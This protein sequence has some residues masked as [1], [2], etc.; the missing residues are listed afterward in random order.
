M[1][2]NILTLNNILDLEQ[3]EEIQEMLADV[4]GMAL[5]TVDYKGVPKTS[6]S[7]CNSFCRI[8]RSN[9]E[10]FKI[11]QRCDSRAGFEAV[12][13]NGPFIYL[14]HC[15][16]V[17]VAIPIIAYEKY[18]GA[19]MAGQVLLVDNDHPLE[20][21]INDSKN[22]AFSLGEQ[23]YQEYAKLPQFTYEKIEKIANMIWKIS[24]YIIKD[25]L[26]K[27][28]LYNLYYKSLNNK[29]LDES[30]DPEGFSITNI[31]EDVINEITRSTADTE[32]NKLTAK[33]SA[34]ISPT[35]RPAIDYI[36]QHKDKMP[37]QNELANLCH[38]S[39]SYFSKLFKK[40]M[41]SNFSQYLIRL[42]ITL[43][44]QMLETTNSPVAQISEDLGFNEAGYFIK[45][46]KKLEGITPAQF[47]KLIK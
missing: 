40:E 32:F 43:A 10:T 38:I 17:D 41:N 1:N 37:T 30:S 35:L 33:N 5:I 34:R 25:S 28:S 15:N 3:W 31:M 7:R 18:I 39:T 42:K 22:T 8:V 2:N 24:N 11:C 20:K 44:K 29:E 23:M 12:L 16:I 47:R 19:I 14:C 4:T 13:L 46:F 45:L 36:F 21:I 9:P 6:H 26:I 27:N